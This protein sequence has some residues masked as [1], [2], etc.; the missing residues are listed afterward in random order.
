MVSGRFLVNLD[1]GAGA[2]INMNAG[3]VSAYPQIADTVFIDPAN[4]V[5]DQLANTA[6]AAFK[7]N[8]VVIGFVVKANPG[9]VAATP[10]PAIAININLA[11]KI[12][13]Q[14]VRIFGVMMV[15]G[16]LS[17]VLVEAINTIVAP[18]PHAA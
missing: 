18:R 15:V 2:I 8:P 10:D 4:G 12:I 17:G 3:G 13:A 9:T 5:A 1:S 7:M 14:A 11:G 6:I 16:K